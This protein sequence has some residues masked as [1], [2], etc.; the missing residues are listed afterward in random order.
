MFAEA[1]RG[2]NKVII[3]SDLIDKIKKP[4]EKAAAVKDYVKE[5]PFMKYGVGVYN[6]F[7]MQKKLF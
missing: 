5:D 2:T 1:K 3:I 7:D 6:F 4:D